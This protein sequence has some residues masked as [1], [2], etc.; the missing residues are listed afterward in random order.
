MFLGLFHC[1][2]RIQNKWFWSSLI[3]LNRVVIISNLYITRIECEIQVWGQLR[4]TIIDLMAIY[5][6]IVQSAVI[7]SRS[8]M[9]YNTSYATNYELLH[10]NEFCKIFVKNVFSTLNRCLS[11]RFPLA[12]LVLELFTYVRIH[13]NPTKPCTFRGHSSSSIMSWTVLYRTSK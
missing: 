9:K 7:N 1:E 10:E 6:E 11:H 8:T 4:S 2:F 5:L 3:V 12:D 13:E